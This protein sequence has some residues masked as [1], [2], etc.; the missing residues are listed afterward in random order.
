M[1][2]SGPGEESNDACLKYED[3]TNPTTWLA[4]SFI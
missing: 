4:V 2:R 3:D 1:G